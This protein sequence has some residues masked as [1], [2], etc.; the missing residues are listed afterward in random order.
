MPAKTLQHRWI[1]IALISGAVAISGCSSGEPPAQTLAKAELAVNE[2]SRGEA[3]QRTAPELNLARSKLEQ[4]RRAMDDERYQ[5][6]RRLAEQAL[7]DAQL[8]E[9]KAEAAD[10]RETLRQMRANIEA[11]KGEAD[12]AIQQVQ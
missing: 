10:E 1:A 8:A 5:D 6:A 7:V 4:A 2:A 12:R 11:L 3:A 9:A